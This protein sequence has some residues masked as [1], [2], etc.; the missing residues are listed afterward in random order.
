MYRHIRFAATPLGENR[1]EIN[2]KSFGSVRLAGS[3]PK[4]L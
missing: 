2:Y 4:D 3:S 1:L